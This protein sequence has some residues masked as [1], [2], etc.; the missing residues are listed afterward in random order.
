[1]HLADEPRRPKK[2]IELYHW[3]TPNG[4]KVTISLEEAGLDYTTRHDEAA[5]SARNM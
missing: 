3:P 2:M 1:L 4:H 5:G